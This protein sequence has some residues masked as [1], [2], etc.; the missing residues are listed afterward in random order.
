MCV[1]E[2]EYGMGEGEDKVGNGI[3]SGRG[4]ERGDRNVCKRERERVGDG[5]ESRLWEREWER[6]REGGI[7]MCVREKERE[8]RG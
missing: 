2:R 5:R 3:G 8:S 7:E 1:K 6:E 4:R